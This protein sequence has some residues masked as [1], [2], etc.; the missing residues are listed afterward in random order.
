MET[1]GFDYFYSQGME[2]IDL[3]AAE[4]CKNLPYG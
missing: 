4:E 1:F 3:V 2:I